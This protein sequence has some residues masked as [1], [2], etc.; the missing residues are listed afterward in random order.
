MSKKAGPRS[1]GGGARLRV[2]ARDRA[3]GQIGAE[4]FSCG[5]RWRPFYASRRW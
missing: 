4:P 5:L 1:R 2:N 3:Q